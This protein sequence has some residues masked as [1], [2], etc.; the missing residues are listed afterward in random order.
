[1]PFSLGGR[2]HLQTILRPQNRQP[3]RQYINVKFKKLKNLTSD[4]SKLSSSFLGFRAEFRR[5][6]RLELGAAMGASSMGSFSSS[7]SE[8]ITFFL[9]RVDMTYF[10]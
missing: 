2:I 5:D 10:Y 8:E 6:G 9:L 7:S 1:M 4:S 3:L